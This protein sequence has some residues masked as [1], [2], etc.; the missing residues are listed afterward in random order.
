MRSRAEVHCN[1]APRCRLWR[2]GM[3]CSQGSALRL[4]RL[5]TGSISARQLSLLGHKV[6]QLVRLPGT[7]ESTIT[8]EVYWKWCRVSCALHGCLPAVSQRVSL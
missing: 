8:E 4:L 1:R 5:S 2:A 3:Q 7:C 6:L